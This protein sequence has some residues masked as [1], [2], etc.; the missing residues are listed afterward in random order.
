MKNSRLMPIILIF[1][2]DLL[3]FSL[4]LPLLPYYAEAY[5]A[6]PTIAGGYLLQHLGIWAPGI[7]NAIHTFLT[8]A[9][10]H[11]RNI[12]S[13]RSVKVVVEAV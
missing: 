3:G 1:I 12:L 8:I 6:T 7:F 2:V 11:W 5:G 13:T 10:T 9:L 4:I